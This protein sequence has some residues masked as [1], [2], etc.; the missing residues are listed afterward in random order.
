MYK[1]IKFTDTIA[2]WSDE[3]I[4]IN[5]VIC[6]QVHHIGF[7]PEPKSLV[8][9]C[10]EEELFAVSRNSVALEKKIAECHVPDVKLLKVTR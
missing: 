2:V 9:N 8:F 7:L 6:R 5:D 4:V 1:L 3:F 10:K